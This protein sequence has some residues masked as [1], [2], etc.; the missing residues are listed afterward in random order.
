MSDEGFLER[1]S[2]R[3][4]AVAESE[5][6]AEPAPQSAAVPPPDA[7]PPPNPDAADAAPEVDLSALPPIE[8][9]S[10]TTDIRAFL[11][12]GVPASLRHAAL[13]RAWSADPTIRDFVG[14]SENS[15]DFTASEGIPGFGPIGSA[16][17]VRRM[18]A[19]LM[20]EPG[21]RAGPPS[22]APPEAAETAQLMEDAVPAERTGEGEEPAVAAADAGPPVPPAG[23]VPEG[24]APDRPGQDD[25]VQGEGPRKLAAP[26]R[27]R[28]LHGG[29]LP[30]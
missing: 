29:A 4:R 24:V 21:E 2:R 11:A 27:V 18:L 25:A 22:S 5:K 6:A 12:P 20:G 16:E 26:T 15:W 19:Q 13:R 14:L 8:S 30:E 17:E 1:W 9:I 10:A 3:K 28:R 7:E 23:E